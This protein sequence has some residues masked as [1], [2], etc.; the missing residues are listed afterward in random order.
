[1]EVIPFQKYL[2]SRKIPSLNIKATVQSSNMDLAESG[3]T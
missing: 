3:I 2:P 1:M